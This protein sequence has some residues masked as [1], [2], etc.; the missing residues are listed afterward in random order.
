MEPVTAEMIEK[1]RST[2]PIRSASRRKMQFQLSITRDKLASHNGESLAYDIEIL[3]IFS[4]CQ[5]EVLPAIATFVIIVALSTYPTL[6]PKVIITWTAF[7]LA[8]I[9]LIYRFARMFLRNC[10]KFT[11]I[12]NWQHKFLLAQ[13]LQASAGL[14]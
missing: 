4:F 3:K 11:R 7:Q 2:P 6:S 13:T 9:V 8:T 1:G 10:D 5:T 12:T 14:S